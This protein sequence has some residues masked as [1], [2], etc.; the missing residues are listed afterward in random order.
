[1][2]RLVHLTSTTCR[3]QVISR[4]E[5]LKDGASTI[6]GSDAVCGVINIIT[7]DAIDDPELNF[8]ISQPFESGGEEYAIDGA[9]GFELGDTATFTF[10]AE[11]RLSEEL[12]TS[13]RNY[14]DCPRDLVR[15]PNGGGLLDRRNF[16]ATATDPLDTCNNLY[17]NT[18]IDAFSGERLI[19]SPDGT[20]VPT[21]FGGAI[22]G[23]RPRVGTGT[24][25]DGTLFYEDI[26]DAPF[27]DNEDFIPRN[28]N[29]S[30]VATSDVTL[31]PIAWDTEVL[32]NKRTTEVEGW[33]QF[34]PFVGSATN[35][36]ANNPIYGYILDPTYSN[37]LNSLVRPVMPFPTFDE[38]EIDYYYGS[39]SF[40][41]DF[42]GLLPDWS[43]KI[44]GTYTRSEGTYTGNEILASRSGDWGLDGVSDFTGDGIPD[45]VAPPSIDYFDPAILSGEN[46]DA[47]VNA[48]QGVQSGE[49]VY[50]QTTLTGVVVGEVFDLPAGPVGL[51]LGYEFRE[52]EIDDTPGE[53]TQSGDIWGSSTAGPTRGRNEVEEVFVETGCA[54]P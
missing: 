15:D 48:V 40:A 25:A 14:L 51:A 1:M 42:A 17:H 8:T 39:T 46:V 13:D 4:I 3:P 52:F 21:I 23:Y 11:Y 6:Y 10:A 29:L 24:T 31:G 5:I 44:D 50:E 37:S 20:T 2:A 41:G 43:W 33:R 26:L 18:A 28:E 49:T 45:P 35:P 47:L 32:Y 7:R 53:L 27:L 38:V 12:D 22:P 54:N 36:A 9:F 30:F 34:F 19:P 16:S